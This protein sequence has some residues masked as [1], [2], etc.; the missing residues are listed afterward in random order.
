M[1]A[2][3]PP[4]GSVP[5]ATVPAGPS[6]AAGTGP[7]LLVVVAGVVGA[8]HVWKLSPALPVLSAE[9][10]LSL[11]QG[12]FLLST[13]QVAGMLLGVVVG[14]FGDR[15][16]LRRGWCWGWACSPRAP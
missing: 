15:I 9:L 4:A 8:L 2:P 13:V 7:A 3:V 5:A 16:G 11:V 14:L 1:S 12:G 6:G 10:G